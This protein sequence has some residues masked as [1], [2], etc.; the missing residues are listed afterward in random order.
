MLVKLRSHAV[1]L[2]LIFFVC[3]WLIVLLVLAASAKTQPH[4]QALS[5]SQTRA[6]LAPRTSIW[7]EK[8]L[9]DNHE[10]KIEST[11][12]S[13][14]KYRPNPIYPDSLVDAEE[15]FTL[16]MLTFNR[17]DLM[18]R[19]L[20]HYSAMRHLDRIVV[21]WNNVDELPPVELWTSLEPHP[22]P[23]LFLPQSENKIQNRLQ[24][25]PQI[26]TKGV[27]SGTMLCANNVCSS[28]IFVLM[29]LMNQIP[30]IFGGI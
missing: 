3:V 30:V 9:N 25:F 28:L 12:R 13:R 10:P 21:V 14:G 22:V 17:T 4:E 11:K 8:R 7:D 20:N 16:L 24:G 18:L 15:K 29:Q 23:V 27:T 2:L 6:T 1:Q 5:S 26:A 19:L